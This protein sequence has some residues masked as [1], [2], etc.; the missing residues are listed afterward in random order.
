MNAEIEAH[1][2]D[3]TI[4]LHNLKCGNCGPVKTKVISLKPGEPAPDAGA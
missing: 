1:P 4:A 3:R 2:T